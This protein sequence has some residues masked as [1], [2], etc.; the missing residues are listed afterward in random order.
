M[1]V[2]IRSFMS[3]LC[4]ATVLLLAASSH[5]S[6]SSWT[7]TLV[8]LT[9]PPDGWRFLEQ[10]GVDRTWVAS[11]TLQDKTNRPNF[12]PATMSGNIKRL[13][14]LQETV[15][16]LQNTG[17]CAV[18]ANWLLG[19][20]L[21][22]KSAQFKCRVLPGLS[23]WRPLDEVASEAAAV[24]GEF[25]VSLR[26]YTHKGH[27]RHFIAWFNLLRGFFPHWL[28]SLALSYFSCYDT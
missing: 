24:F 27:F 14:D 3:R 19:I 23:D 5:D 9:G 26:C 17:T 20:M 11:Q 16:C 7:Q 10:A 21:G 28:L 6:E 8:R 25:W 18:G 12:F 2:L 22:V 4:R 15:W 13:N 1:S